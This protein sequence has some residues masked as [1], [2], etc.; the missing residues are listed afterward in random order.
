MRPIWMAGLAGA[1]VG[2]AASCVVNLEGAPCERDSNC[3]RSQYCDQ[4]QPTHQC[5]EIVKLTSPQEG[6]ELALESLSQRL[7]ECAAGLPEHW[8]AQGEVPSV[9]GAIA[10]SVA[11]GR[12]TFDPSKVRECRAGILNMACGDLL[13]RTYGLMIDGCGMFQGTV[14]AGNACTAHTDCA[15]GYCDTISRCP[16]TCRPFKA[17]NDLCTAADLC[18]PGSTCWGGSCRAFITSGTCDAG[19]CNQA[20]HYCNNQQC[21]PREGEAAQGCAYV[22]D[23][24]DCQL[25]LNC[26]GALLFD[27]R[28]CQKGKGLNEPCVTYENE[29]A[30]FTSCQ[31]G[32]GGHFCRLNP[33]PGG[34][35]GLQSGDLVLCTGSRCTSAFNGTCA[36]FLAVGADCSDSAECGPVARCV[37]GRCIAEYC[38]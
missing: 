13:N 15:D 2:I 33:G 26:T 4:S 24:Y 23:G 38:L 3:P 30:R 6:C 32:D 7:S 19:P 14:A 27:P 9:C 8:Y 10:A 17:V 35:C 29:C 1:A 5:V 20:T 18:A 12:Q 16:G 11:A 21:L 31:P 28:S 22:G 34:M 25:T 36:N 37:N